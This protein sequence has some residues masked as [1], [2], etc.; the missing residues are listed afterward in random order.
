MR[1]PQQEETGDTPF[2]DKVYQDIAASLKDVTFDPAG[3]DKTDD[4]Y[5]T[6]LAE[7]SGVTQAKLNEVLKAND[8]SAST[9]PNKKAKILQ[10]VAH[11]RNDE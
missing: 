2:D 11:I 7:T 10:L 4:A 5:A 3:L 9:G 8:L 1:V 6:S